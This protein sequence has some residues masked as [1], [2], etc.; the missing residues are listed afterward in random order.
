MSRL[1]RI[2][3]LL[4]GLASLTSGAPQARGRVEPPTGQPKRFISDR[5][6]FSVK[7][8][9]GWQVFVGSD[10]PVYFNFPPPEL[11][12]GLDLPKGGATI[13]MDAQEDAHGKRRTATE[14]EWIALETGSS[15]VVSTS[16]VEMPPA[17]G[18]SDAVI[19]SRDLP[20]YALDDQKQREVSA[21]WRFRGGGFAAH[22]RYVQGDP[23]SSQYESILLDVVRSIRPLQRESVSPLK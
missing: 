10:T 4:W 5:F 9:P 16:R 21:Y 2:A 20:V 3:F 14:S 7:V 13:D 22:V 19:V 23:K 6:G 1:S 15:R 12:P 18:I 11:G 8:P 17:S